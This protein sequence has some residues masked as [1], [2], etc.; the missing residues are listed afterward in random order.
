MRRLLF[1]LLIIPF[2]FSAV[3]AKQK[4]FNSGL[5]YGEH[6]A[7]F[8]SAP[9]GWVLD[10]GSAAVD[11]V[12]AAFYPVGGSWKSSM[13]VMYANGVDK[14]DDETLDHFIDGDVEK[15]SIDTP[16]IKIEDAEFPSL[17]NKTMRAKRFSKDSNGIEMV[18]YIDEPK[19]VS[20]I[21]L[22]AH[23]RESFERSYQAFKDLVKSYKFMTSDVRIK[24]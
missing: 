10:N 12:H 7:F 3:N 24:K 17:P 22:S 15:F 20:M 2:S 16:E 18:V 13:A 8:V 11:G 9:A 5:V 23:S 14:Q 4:E 6:H 19:S 1:A 21:V